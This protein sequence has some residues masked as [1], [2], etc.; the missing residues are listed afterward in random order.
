MGDSCLFDL[1]NKEVK[2]HMKLE[3]GFIVLVTKGENAGSIGKIEEIRDGLFSLPKRTVIHLV[4]GQL[5]CQ[6]KW[7]C[8]S[9]LK[10]R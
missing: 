9:V 1:S 6:Y 8:W 3:K 10:S 5:S 2:S 7:S 4:I